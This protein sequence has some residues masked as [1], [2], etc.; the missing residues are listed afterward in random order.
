[1]LASDVEGSDGVGDGHL[2]SSC[3]N[4]IDHDCL[5][6]DSTVKAGYSDYKAIGDR[7]RHGVR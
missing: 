5:S 4:R 6:S 3:S 7:S 1:M 2:N